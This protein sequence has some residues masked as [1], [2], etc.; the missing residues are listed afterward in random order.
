MACLY[1][2][3]TCPQSSSLTLNLDPAGS[4]KARE[5]IGELS[6]VNRCSKNPTR[7]AGVDD[8]A[9]EGFLVREAMGRFIVGIGC[10]GVSTVVINE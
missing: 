10:Q 5:T 2:A 8:K 1:A 3:A 4:V 9:T 7:A 6:A